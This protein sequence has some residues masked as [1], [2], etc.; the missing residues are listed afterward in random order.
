MSV[1]SL[2]PAITSAP[3]MWL[4]DV[5]AVVIRN[6]IRMRRSPDIIV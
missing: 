6:L 1:T 4:A 5:R 3:A 2:T